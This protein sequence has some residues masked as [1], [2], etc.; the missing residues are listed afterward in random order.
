MT[1]K[2]LL[3]HRFRTNANKLY[4]GDLLQPPLG[5]AYRQRI[6]D[7]RKDGFE[8]EC[9]PNDVNPSLTVYKLKEPEPVYINKRGQVEFLFN[10]EVYRS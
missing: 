8:I 2:E 5:A 10:D 1:Q 3:L 9:I 7:L 6:S 4:L